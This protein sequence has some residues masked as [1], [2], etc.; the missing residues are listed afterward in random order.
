MKV[1]VRPW[2]RAVLWAANVQRRLLGVYF[3]VV[4]P[5]VAYQLTARMA[6]LMYRLLSP[7]RARSEAQCRAALSSRVSPED[8]PRLA[9]Q[10]FVHRMWNLTDLLL[11]ERL[12]HT[13]TWQRFGGVIPEPHLGNMLDAQLRRQP[14]I[15]ISAYYGPYD[16]LPM[17]LGYNGIRAAAIYQT[18]GNPSFDEQ[19]RR[20]R[21]RG[22]CELVPLTHTRERVPEVLERG[23][24]VAIIADHHAPR[25]G[26]PVTFLGLPTMALRSVGL[27]AWRYKA[28]IA[29]AGIR[30]L[31][32]RFRFEI[33]VIDVI[34]PIDWE[35]AGNPVKYI[36]D[37]YLRALE[38]LVLRDPTQYI[39]AYPRWGEDLAQRLTDGE[40]PVF[41]DD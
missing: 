9:E 10:A 22:G 36:T 23:G 29:A 7:L 3:A 27:L 35:N 16:L 39:W 37:R 12:M 31:D 25:R 32:D 26:L 19:R 33:D 6:R 8:V 14:T 21:R 15:L 11:A 4:G 13:R 38:A 17:F 1:P 28:E 18:H 41:A 5:R 30:R 20:V 40:A 34:K 24:A 2:Q